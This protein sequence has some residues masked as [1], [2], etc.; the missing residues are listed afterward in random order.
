MDRMKNEGRSVLPSCPSWL[1]ILSILFIALP[2]WA[3]ALQ[4]RLIY[5]TRAGRAVT[6]QVV[7]GGHPAFISLQ[8]EQGD[9]EILRQFVLVHSGPEKMI[10]PGA[11]PQKEQAPMAWKVTHKGD[12][13]LLKGRE[14]TFW[15]YTPGLVLPV[16]FRIQKEE[17]ALMAADLPPKMMVERG[18]EP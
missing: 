1:F 10:D 9:A 12:R 14:A 13:T 18:G 8:R 15:R 4:G 5:R 2:T 17:W 3:Q 7:D 16:R 11:L 6:F